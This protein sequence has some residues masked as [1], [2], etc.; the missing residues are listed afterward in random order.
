MPQYPP[1]TPPAQPRWVIRLD[2]ACPSQ[3]IL[4]RLH[5]GV[6]RRVKQEWAWRLQTNKVAR[7]IP[8]ATG[9]RR[10]TIERHSRGTLDTAN[11]I[12]G[13]KG[14]IDDMVAMGLF[15]DDRPAD[16]ILE[17]PVQCSLRRGEHPCTLLIIENVAIEMVA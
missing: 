4:D 5:W 2:S 14:I 6:R 16:L 3:N 12:G 10:L 17:L 13:A 1:E 8:K 9:P 15:L 7:S 11:L